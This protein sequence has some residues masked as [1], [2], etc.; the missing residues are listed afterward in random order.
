MIALFYMFSFSCPRDIWKEGYQCQCGTIVKMAKCVI[1]S[2]DVV[3]KDRVKLSN[4]GAK[5]I[6]SAIVKRKDSI[7]K[8][9][10]GQIVHERCRKSYCSKKTI[11]QILKKKFS[12]NEES[13]S[14]RS[15]RAPQSSFGFKDHCLFCG[16]LVNGRNKIFKVS[17]MKFQETI[18]KTGAKRNDR[19]GTEV[20]DR[21]SKISS[22]IDESALYHQTCSIYFRNLKSSVP[23]KFQKQKNDKLII[24]N[25]V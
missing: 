1:C 4:I 24:A 9:T 10:V 21:I 13:K 7:A 5:S 20:I 23:S 18:M 25:H 6:N 2:E 22:L 11:D 15:R 19:W 3:I 8:V 17:D 12:E 16:V 14:C